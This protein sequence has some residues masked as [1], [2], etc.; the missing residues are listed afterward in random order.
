MK[1]YA[2]IRVPEVSRGDYVV[3]EAARVLSFADRFGDLPEPLR[4]HLAVVVVRG[5]AFERVQQ[6]GERP[7]VAPRPERTLGKHVGRLAPHVPAEPGVGVLEAVGDQDR[8]PGGLVE[9]RLLAGRDAVP[10]EERTQHV[11]RVDPEFDRLAAVRDA[12]LRGPFDGVQKL[13]LPARGHEVPLPAGALVDVEH[14]LAQHRRV[15]DAL[16]RIEVGVFEPGLVI[17]RAIGELSRARLCGDRPVDEPSR[18]L[19]ELRLAGGVQAVDRD[20]LLP[21]LALH[22]PVE[23]VPRD[24]RHEVRETVRQRAG[25]HVV[26]HVTLPTTGRQKPVGGAFRE[27]SFARCHGVPVGRTARAAG[28]VLYPRR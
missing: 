22:V 17:E 3:E 10:R 6:A 9:G 18:A 16:Q 8:L 5:Q 28:N 19:E 24:S 27:G 15:G 20:R 12:A 11:H 4:E 14:P 23:R 26:W 13:V 7:A 21:V 25:V 2:N 1:A